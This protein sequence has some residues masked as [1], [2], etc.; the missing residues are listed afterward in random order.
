MGTQSVDY[1]FSN[2]APQADQHLSSLEEY[3][4]PVT[5]ACL[6]ELVPAGSGMRCLE[7][8]PGRGSMTHWLVDRVGPAGRVVAIDRDPS[9]L[10]SAANLE[11]VRHDLQQGLPVAGRFDLVHARLVMLHLPNRIPLLRQLVD[12]LAPGGWIV[13]GEFRSA[14]LPIVLTPPG[15]RDTA[16][17]ARVVAGTLDLLGTRYGMDNQWGEQVHSALTGAGL[18]PVAT[19]T[20]TGTWTGGGPGCGM[21]SACASQKHDQLLATGLTEPE[22]QR[23]YALMADPQFSTRAW[24]FV[25]VSGQRP[26][27]PG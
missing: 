1:A 18:R 19:A 6:R 4:D 11:I 24:P 20:H 7:L 8:G 13:I 17:F 16:L 2:S 27:Q 12:Q 9:Q 22:L 5:V 25:C 26:G 21:F 23:F 15:P 10:A 3:L 14:E